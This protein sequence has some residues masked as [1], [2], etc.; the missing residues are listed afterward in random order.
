[1][2]Q[3]SVRRIVI[4][5]LGSRDGGLRLRFQSAVRAILF[6]VLLAPAFAAETGSRPTP[7]L[8]VTKLDQTNLGV[9]YPS[10]DFD[11]FLSA[12]SERADIQKRYTHL[13]LQY[14][15]YADISGN[16]IECDVSEG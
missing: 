16:R 4:R 15:E 13:P 7:S 2:G 9:P 1:M 12:F 3:Q 8:R 11:R 6:L 5:H 14:G 10:E